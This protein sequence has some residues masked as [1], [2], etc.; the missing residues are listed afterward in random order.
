[1]VDGQKRPNASGLI[2]ESKEGVLLLT[3]DNPPANTLTNAVVAKL[4]EA[5]EGVRTSPGTRGVV[6]TGA[7]DRFFTAGGDIKETGLLDVEELVVRMRDFHSVLE[8]IE[9]ADCP[10]AVAVNGA[11]V[12]GGV[13]FCLFADYT[14]SVP[15]A[16]FGFPEINHGVLPAAKGMQQAARV[17]GLRAARR[18]LYS[19]ELLGAREAHEIGFIDEVVD[20]AS[21][22]DV[23]RAWVGEM[24]DKGGALFGGV[25]RALTLGE[26]L[27]DR[28]LEEL[29]TTDVRRYFGSREA[30][31][32]RAGWLSRKAQDAEDAGR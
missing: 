7:G 30:Q 11:S 3:L 14:V 26:E 32:A 12:G 31:A 22:V 17:V 20:D 5:F 8:A 21:V 29:T 4:R 2:E 9:R 18:L 6:L 1:M 23:A 27:S 28:L 19:G 13:E 25:K 10:V 16:R 24:A 15:H